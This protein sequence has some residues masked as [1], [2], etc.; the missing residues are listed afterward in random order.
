M[1]G[2]GKYAPI[3]VYLPHDGLFDVREAMQALF[4]LLCRRGGCELSVL[5]IMGQKRVPATK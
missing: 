3:T 4:F 5:W 2:M 1:G